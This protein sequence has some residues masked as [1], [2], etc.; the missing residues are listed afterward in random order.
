MCASFLRHL[1]KTQIRKDRSLTVG[2]EY[3]YF[4]QQGTDTLPR[5]RDI[6]Q[7]KRKHLQFIWGGRGHGIRKLNTVSGSYWECAV[8][9]FLE[10]L[11]Y[12]WKLPCPCYQ[13]VGNGWARQYSEKEE[14][15]IS[16]VAGR[17]QHTSGNGK[18][19]GQS[20]A[21]Y[22]QGLF[23]QYVW[24]NNIDLKNRG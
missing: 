16:N 18:F 23:P 5:E 12:L 2:E 19:L 17:C 21:E 10:S 9:T 13:D 15:G 20:Q 6:C 4:Q 3:V 14:S 22:I 7:H 8:S 1:K 11:F 24:T